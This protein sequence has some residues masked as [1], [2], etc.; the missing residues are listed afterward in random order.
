LPNCARSPRRCSWSVLPKKSSPSLPPLDYLATLS[1]DTGVI[2]HAVEDVPNR[3]TGYCTDDVSR[4]FMVALARMNLKPKDAVADWLASIYL[5]FLYDAQ[6][7]DGRFHNFMS[8]D[9]EWLDAIGTQDSIGR[10]IWSL[11]YGMRFSGWDSWRRVCT[12]MLDRS[13][14]SLDHLTFPR[15]RAYAMIGLAHAIQSEA[16]DTETYRGALSRFAGALCDL[17]RATRDGEWEW[18]E[19]IMTYDN[20]RLCEALLRSGPVLR[21]DD[22]TAV[23]LR[24]LAF[25]EQ[26]TVEDGVYVPIGNDGWFP[27]GGKRARYA[28][29]PLEAAA[30]IDAELAALDA[31]GDSAHR[32]MAYAGMGWYYGRNSREI[33]MVRDDG[34]CRDGLEENRV[35]PNMGA[36]STLAFLAG[37]YAMAMR[38][39]R[40]RRGE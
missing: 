6:S 11:G 33:V 12:L 24:T 27:R 7:E 29:Q 19:E 32:S 2:Q 22:I 30:L 25:Y 16:G 40:A 39:N 4:G 20:A 14:K 13:V 28:Q 9:R 31:T 37:A 23:G 18:F 17:Y 34:G 5:A 1:D 26:V 15:S 8:Y 38:G 3:S 21:D 35:N 36:E 10:A